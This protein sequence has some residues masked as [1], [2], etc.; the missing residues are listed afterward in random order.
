MPIMFYPRN[1]HKMAASNK[2]SFWP[3]DDQGAELKKNT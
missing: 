1:E 2:L 3:L